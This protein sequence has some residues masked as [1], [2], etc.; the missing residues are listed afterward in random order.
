MISSVQVG[1]NIYIL[2]HQLAQHN[3]ELKALLKPSA[4]SDPKVK[5]ALHHYNTHT[6]QIEVRLDI[7]YCWEKIELIITLTFFQIA[8][9]DRTL[10]QIVFPIPEQCAYL[11]TETKVKVYQTVE[12][13]DQGSKVSEFFS[14]TDDLYNEM[15]WQKKLRSNFFFIMR[16]I[17][18][19]LI[20]G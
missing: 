8:R 12:K 2:C 11:T 4:V 16:K 19:I 20:V 13:D 15:N 7:R 18:V 17:G 3:K 10:E 1:H 6:A 5:E 9:Q 14:L